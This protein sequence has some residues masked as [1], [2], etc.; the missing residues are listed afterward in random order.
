MSAPGRPLGNEGALAPW[1][2]AAR[3]VA[4]GGPYMSTTVLTPASRNSLLAL[5]QR[6]RYKE[7]HGALAVPSEP[8]S[9]PRQDLPGAWRELGTSRRAT[10]DQL[11]VRMEQALAMQKVADSPRRPA[12]IASRLRRADTTTPSTCWASSNW[13]VEISTTRKT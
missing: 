12:N 8:A 3:S 9:V 7:C 11:G 1:G 4:S 2:E 13:V 5:R 6:R 10:R